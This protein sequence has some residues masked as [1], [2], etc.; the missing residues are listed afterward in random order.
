MLSCSTQLWCRARCRHG[1]TKVK[2][3]RNRAQRHAPSNIHMIGKSGRVHLARLRAKRSA[4]SGS[5]ALAAGEAT[6]CSCGYGHRRVYDTPM[7]V[8]AWEFL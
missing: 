5:R 3:F 2:R 8:T 1:L 7:K 6:G 4:A